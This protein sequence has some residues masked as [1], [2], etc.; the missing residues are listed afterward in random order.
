MFK[1][2]YHFYRSSEWVKFREAYIMKRLERDNDLICDY[3]HKA[4]T[5]KNDAIL[6]HTTFLND[7]NVN[8]YSISLNEDNIM[9]VH[10]NCHN[11]IHYRFN[12]YTRHI[13]L[14][15][16]SPCSGKSTFVKNAAMNDDLIVDI[17]K[18]Y[19][20]ISIN[21][22][23]TKSNRLKYNVF[24][25]Y[26]LLV[27]MIKTRNGKWINAFI[28]GG[29]ARKKDR[30]DLANKL[31]AELV[32]IDEDKNV[33]LERAFKRGGEVYQSYVEKW[34]NEYQE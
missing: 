20:C 25:I 33:C 22:L 5:Q 13:Y 32:F 30:E 1:N 7:V 31:N 4:I 12:S 23:H 9:L 10:H 8:D 11:K 24:Q 19:E 3:C 29:Y 26:D 18:I 6:H 17:D 16:G 27:D 28:I 14:V 2:T 15:Y 21:D 34:F